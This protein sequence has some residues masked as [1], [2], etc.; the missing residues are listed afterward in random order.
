MGKKI[1]FETY[2]CA[3]NRADTL[4]LQSILEDNGV[5]IV[6]NLEEADVI[7]INTC[8]VKTPTEN[9]M[10]KRIKEL[11]EKFAIKKNKKIVVIGCIVPIYRKKIEDEYKGV[12]T[13]YR[14]EYKEFLEFL[15]VRVQFDPVNTLYLKKSM[16]EVI[17]II[18]ICFGCLGCC[19]YCITRLA[20]GKVKS[21]E[22][23]EIIDV[24]K[25]FLKKGI[26]EFWLTSQDL[27]VYG[28]DLGCTIV[29]LLEEI[30]KLP[31]T[32]FV[33]LGMI[34]PQWVKEYQNDLFKLMADKHFFNFLH[35]PIQSGSDKIL[36]SMNRKYT[37]EEVFEIVNYYKSFLKDCTIATDVIVGYPGETEEDFM[38][39]L[40]AINFIKPDFINI[41][42]FWPRPFTIAASLK[43][44]PSNIKSFRSKY[45]RNFWE[46]LSLQKKMKLVGSYRKVLVD[47]RGR[48][49]YIGR[50][51]AY[52]SFFIKD[53][54][55]GDFKEV[56][57]VGTTPYYF[58]GE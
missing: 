50:D 23:K 11:Y 40:E 46:A 56:K 49:G 1:Y 29:D 44:T 37:I 18:P 27:G 57:I 53:V 10:F 33:R 7:V 16:N 19:S 41:S 39:T 43:D 25:D 26:K 32:F 6:N 17:A 12:L 48:G 52:R 5:K 45:L 28:V 35:I 13:F 54:S 34:N 36:K 55:L 4:I 22:I 2:G 9:K 58:I 21:Y 38:K 31:G 3:L 47:E 20:R 14:D 42:K 51:I 24:M 8:I 15:G 30:K